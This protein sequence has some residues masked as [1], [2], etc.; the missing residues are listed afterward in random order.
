VNRSQTTAWDST[1]EELDVAHVGAVTCVEYV[2][3]TPGSIEHEAQVTA[4]SSASEPQVIT[5]AVRIDGAGVDWYSVTIRQVTNLIRIHRYVAGAS[6]EIYS[7][8]L[9]ITAGNFVTV[10]LAAAGAVGDN[11]VLSV[12]VTEHSTTK[13]ADPG[14]IGV[15]GSPDFTYTDTA[16]TRLDAST[17]DACGIGGSSAISADYDT[18]LCFWKS[19][20]ISD[21]SGGGSSAAPLAAAYYA[22]RRN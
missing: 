2:A 13:P 5:A 11:V 19:R 18:R 17:H 15:D 3:N 14:W 4:L 6:T 20:A 16:G 22:M 7:A 10:R 1:D 21:R 8:A 12:W 9:T